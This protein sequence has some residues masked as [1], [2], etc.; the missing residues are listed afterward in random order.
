M[1]MVSIS[2]QPV[3]HDPPVFTNSALFHFQPLMVSAPEAVAQ[4]FS[5]WGIPVP[6]TETSFSLEDTTPAWLAQV[7]LIGDGYDV[8]WA[9]AGLGWPWSTT[10]GTYVFLAGD[11]ASFSGFTIW[12]ESQGHHGVY[13]P[14]PVTGALGPL[15]EVHT[16]GTGETAFFGDG[17]PVT[18]AR[19]VW[20]FSA[21]ED[22]A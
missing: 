10:E 13:W 2:V 9:V 21:V 8:D 19:Q 6:D 3:D 5:S 16:M 17:P 15:G 14:I 7:G 4:A 22:A 20:R 11:A 12:T 18:G 1:G